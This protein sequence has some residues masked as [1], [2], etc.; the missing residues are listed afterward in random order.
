MSTDDSGQ[1][2]ALPTVAQ[3]A[4]GEPGAPYFPSAAGQEAAPEPGFLDRNATAIIGVLVVLIALVA[5][6]VTLLV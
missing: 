6:L 2:G 1:A 5:A 3:P 4:D